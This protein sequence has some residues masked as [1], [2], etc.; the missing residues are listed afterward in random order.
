MW[1]S[2]WR[3]FPWSYR[4]P[5]AAA[6][7]PTDACQSLMV[8][9]SVSSVCLEEGES[10]S[11]PPLDAVTELPGLPAPPRPSTPLRTDEGAAAEPDS[12]HHLKEF[13]ETVTFTQDSF[14]NFSLN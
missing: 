7:A 2:L 12:P 9:T 8:V 3:R 13:P 1:T 5:G 11:L 10:V 6:A 14:Y 4:L